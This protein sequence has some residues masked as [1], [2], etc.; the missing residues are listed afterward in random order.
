MDTG[1]H[2]FCDVC[3]RSCKC[4]TPCTYQLSLAEECYVTD[5]NTSM[6]PV[7]QPTDEE[8]QDLRARLQ[9]L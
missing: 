6:E 7:Q 8:M 3:T 2:I 9:Q 1:E 5:V 4:N